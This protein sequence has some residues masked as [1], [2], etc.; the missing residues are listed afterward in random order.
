M[1]CGRFN[2]DVAK[3]KQRIQTNERFGSKDLN[4]WIFSH[5]DLA[6]GL[7]ILD[8]GCGTGKQTIPLAQLVGDKGHILAVDISQKALDALLQ[9][10]QELGF[11]KQ[12][13]SLCIGLNDLGK[14]LNQYHFDRVLASYSLYYAR[15]P[16]AVLKVIHRI[17]IPSGILFFCGPAKG[18]NFEIKQFHYALL[19]ISPS[20]A[21]EAI[22]FMENTGQQITRKLFSRVEIYHFE[23]PISFDSAQ[24]LYDYWSSH[25][26]YDEHL[27]Y[28]FKAAARKYF[29]NNSVFTN[30]KRVIGVRAI[31]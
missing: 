29:Q 16:K 31:E 6:E 25:N 18:N 19:G 28:R 13:S 3:L 5:I 17:L 24:S 11:N 2:T 12:I 4:D 26:L 7:S 14:Y 22:T 8:F 15:Y 21:N 30:V 27:E 9:S 1:E 10:A 20:D 23:N